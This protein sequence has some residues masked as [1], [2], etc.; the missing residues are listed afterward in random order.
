MIGPV[1]RRPLGK[2]EA[3]LHWAILLLGAAVLATVVLAR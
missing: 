2:R 3:A 1:H